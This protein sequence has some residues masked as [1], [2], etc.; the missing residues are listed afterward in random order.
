MGIEDT[1]ILMA[2]ILGEDLYADGVAG[3]EI[4]EALRPY[5]E[6][7]PPPAEEI[8][9]DMAEPA[10]AW[11]ARKNQILRRAFA[12]KR[13]LPYEEIKNLPYRELVK[14]IPPRSH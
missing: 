14:L 13:G 11:R 2:E 5:T 9:F 12:L 4:Y 8:V 7:R 1:M 6:K 3:Q 10:A